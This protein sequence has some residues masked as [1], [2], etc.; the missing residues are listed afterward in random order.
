MVVPAEITAKH[1]VSQEAVF[2]HGGEAKGMGD[3]VY[4]FA[5][6]G[7]EH[8]MMARE[9]FRGEDKEKTRALGV[10]LAGVPVSNVLARLEKA[11]FNA[12]GG[13]LENREWRLAWL[14]WRGYHR[15]TF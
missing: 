12:F 9:A 4:A 1:G 2:R 8:L 7:N 3:A 14:L 5:T 10:F 15:G 13:R 11:N 6:L